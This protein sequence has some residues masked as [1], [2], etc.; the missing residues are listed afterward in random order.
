MSLHKLT[1]GSGYDYLTRQVA[2]QDAT[3]KGYTGLASYYTERG[4]TPGMWVGS[5]CADIGEGFLHSVVSAE[6]MQAL[7]GAGMHPLG[8]ETLR[9]L[10]PSLPQRVADEAM[11]LG[12]PY[13]VSGRVDEFRIEVARR[14][15]ELNKSRGLRRDAPVSVD[16]RA[17]IRTAV[18]REVFV[19]EFG[20]E[21]RDA[22]ELAG[23]IARHSRPAATAVA[24]FD[25]TFSP[26]KSVSTLW[27]VADPTIAARIEVAHQKAVAEAL[28]FIESN[29]LYSREGTRG[30]RQVDVTGLVAAAFT[31][32]DSRAGDPDLHTHVAVANKV[33]TV[34]SGKWLSIDARVL[35]RGVVAASETYNTALTKLLEREGL[36]FTDR[37]SRSGR[38]PVREIAGV[39][40]ELNERW[41]SRRAD[42]EVRR[43]DL[44]AAFQADHG[45]PPS[46]VES[47]KLA[48]QATLETRDAKHEPRSL[49]EQ[50]AVWHRQAV[51]TLGSEGALIRMLDRTLG[52][53][54]R[55]DLRRADAAWFEATADRIVEVMEARAAT[56]QDHHMR[57]EALRMVRRTDIP[58]D[59]VDAAVNLLVTTAADRSIRLAR[60]DLGITEPGPLLRAD[61]TSVYTV[62]GADLFTSARVVAAEHQLVELAGLIGGRTTAPV[63]VGAALEASAQAGRELN[64][65]QVELVTAMATSGRR[66]QLAIAPAGAG[67]TTA[68]QALA[69]AWTASAGTV[70]GLAP[71]AA[72]AAQL[73]EQT[74]TTTE[75]LA[76]LAW[77]ITHQDLPRWA[78]Q[79]GSDTLLVIDEAGMADTLSLAQVCAWAVERGASVRLIG[80]TQQLAAIGAGGALRDIQTRHGAV[81]LTELMRFTDPAESAASLALRDGDTSALGFYLDQQRVHV[82]DLA[83]MTDHAFTAWRTDTDQGLDSIML[84]PTRQLV[85]ELNQRAR[86]HRLDQQPDTPRGREC[87][88]ADGCNASAGDTVIT[89]SNDRRLRI[90]RTD[91]VKNGDRWTIQQITRQGDL[92]VR[93]AGTG[94][95]V[96]LPRDYVTASVELGYATTVHSAQG[97]S[98][99]TMHG[100]AT[101]DESRQQFYTMMTRGRHANHVW[102]QVVGDGD[103]DTLIRPEGITPPTPTD[104]LEAILARDES[105]T[106]ATTL[107]HQQADPRLLLGDATQRYLD[108]LTVAAEHHLGKA[109]V[110]GLDGRAEQLLPG[111]SEA[112]AW[113]TL[114]AHLLLLGAQDM[115][116]LDRLADA[117]DLRSLAGARDVAALLSWRLD[118]T[119]LHNAQRGTLPWIPAIPAALAN[120]PI[121]GAWLT[122]RSQLVADLADE[123]RNQALAAETDP[124]WVPTGVRRP[125]VGVIAD[126]EVWRAAMQV[127][128]TDLRP[129]GPAALSRAGLDWQRRLNQ[130]IRQGTAPA[131][132]EWGELLTQINPAI[133]T[134][135]YLPQLAENLAGLARTGYDAARLLTDAAA[136]GPVPDDH[137]A[138][139]IW[140]RIRRATT[141]TIAGRWVDRLPTIVGTDTARQ[142]TESPLW[143]ALIQQV[144][145]AIERGWQP[146]DILEPAATVDDQDPC[147]ALLQRI[148]TLTAMPGEIHVE[149]PDTLPPDDL[150]E[151][152]LPPDPAT[153]QAPALAPAEAYDRLAPENVH[154]VEAEIAIA[155][156][157][158]NTMGAP[159][160]TQADINRMFDRADAW[161]TSPVTRERLV[162]INQLTQDFYTARFP[163]SWSQTYLVDR[164][165]ADLAGHPLVRPG[166][167]PAGW[168]NLIQHLRRQGVTD[169][170]MLTAGVARTASTGR[171][172][173]QFRDRITFPITNDRG[174][175]LGFVARRHPAAADDGSAG[176]K[177]LNTAETPL[178]HKGDQFYGTLRAGT[179]PVIVEGP[180]DG[181]AVTL[182]SHGRYTG[183]APL[184]TSLT[185][186]QAALLQGHPDVV[187]ATD[188]DLAGYVAAE[189]DYWQLTPHGIDPRRAAFSEGTDPAD[190]LISQ[191]VNA[192]TNTLDTAAPMA[193]QMIT[194][195]TN[196]LPPAEALN[197]AAQVA[198]ARPP[199]HWDTDSEI[200]AQ[201]LDTPLAT[202]RETL[203]RHTRT[204]NQDPQQAADKI[205]FRST[206]VRRRLEAANR[207]DRWAEVVNQVDPRLTSQ[208]E[209]PALARTI[210]QAHEAGY[211]AEK[212]VRLL[213]RPA[214]A[215]HRP[216]AELRARLTTTLDLADEHTSRPGR[217]DTT[218]R[219]T[220]EPISPRRPT[221]PSPHR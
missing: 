164:F 186:Q 55:P 62:A 34:G 188:A 167:A 163:G 181:I 47:V 183:L 4:E 115:N 137:A 210:Q 32:R 42:I 2:V 219:E 123:V 43:A 157:L 14:I 8:P 81:Q 148:G 116:P 52:A 122:Q 112:P 105:P 142:L 96:T 204:W 67:K 113:P 205:L 102:L 94:R 111:I 221:A 83:T 99:D 136:Q 85:A 39:A 151:G 59:R 41:S 175:I 100:V 68:M 160:P 217:P 88:L 132:A 106:S 187:I 159:E 58:F 198:A 90:S 56:W 15:D 71:S 152:W 72:A 89:R 119:G 190:Q 209:W 13:R 195:R 98:V 212:A 73:R 6:Q 155:A 30:V 139:A 165:G 200:I 215:S 144:D 1:A 92:Q 78:Q 76:K 174:E 140:W 127:E 69:T 201:R 23:T 64:V 191:G 199:Q 103:D 38:R 120:H 40:A 131:M 158:R 126:V 149:D 203:A 211:D 65:G 16:D 9:H 169:T 213:A 128:P 179:I 207:A 138:A 63:D 31:H 196:N 86:Q 51:E 46:V 93:H 130:Q 95:L 12:V 28:K 7:F 125:P 147:L 114:R 19:R 197:Q 109:Y 214:Q 36:R 146:I 66:L 171:L 189:R 206:D 26:P 135:D 104:A 220:R 143:P 162:Q 194:E 168:T 75:T 166:H 37:A 80:D 110:T 53:T 21:P 5:G 20:R 84:A 44:V 161:R 192:L 156:L 49:A 70:L 45:R 202:V 57:A 154:D 50:R 182:G 124:A 18:A 61:G 74:G 107:L 77:S 117:I 87:V 60:P 176:P 170:E 3:E 153:H 216:A 24:G 97:V 193:H 11:R 208:P 48:Q 27:A 218:A 150:A 134:D 108:G 17:R 54:G 185:G 172:I 91:W 184:G 145:E 141:P 29:L 82:G 180:M 22:R 133:T 101:G 129:T 178:F 79:V 177:Y 25:L 121:F 173:D 10:D 35:Y 118:D 33:R